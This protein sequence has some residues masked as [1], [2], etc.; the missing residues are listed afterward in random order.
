MC[1]VIHTAW[2][3]INVTTVLEYAVTW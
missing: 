2:P 1:T 3:K